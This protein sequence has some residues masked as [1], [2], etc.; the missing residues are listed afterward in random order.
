M[1]EFN[2]NRT[3]EGY[4]VGSS[5]VGSTWDQAAAGVN[6]NDSWSSAMDKMDDYEKNLKIRAELA[7]QSGA[8]RTSVGSRINRA[9]FYV[10]ISLITLVGAAFLVAIYNDNIINFF[11]QQAIRLNGELLS[12]PSE[13]L[14][15]QDKFTQVLPEKLVRDV[16]LI[17]DGNV[18][19]QSKRTDPFYRSAYLCLVTPACMSAADQLEFVH[20]RHGPSSLF[21]RLSA[22]GYLLTRAEDGNQSAIKDVCLAWYVSWPNGSG[23]V[24]GRLYCK[25]MT[26]PRFAS[27]ASQKRLDSLTDSIFM[28]IA[29]KLR[30]S[31]LSKSQS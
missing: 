18:K 8:Y 3:S 21:I 29:E 1:D 15:A 22:M 27:E 26:K 31:P 4:F 25:A 24:T 10:F 6:R 14:S 16:H 23:L 11:I 28:R 30:L 9:F 17:F 2:T 20:A 19:L 13:V 7:V 12:N 5:S